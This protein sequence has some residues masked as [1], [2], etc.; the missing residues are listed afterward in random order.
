M[1]L[2][3]LLAYYKSGCRYYEMNMAVKG[4]DSRSKVPDM[5]NP[6]SREVELLRAHSA[7]QPVTVRNLCWKEFR[8]AGNLLVEVGAF[9]YL[10]FV[11]VLETSAFDGAGTQMLLCPAFEIPID[12]T[13]IRAEPET[14]QQ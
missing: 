9:M 8:V 7:M 6:P 10:L 11:R 14:S 3:S 4:K 13:C 2:P 5:F 1:S 12:S